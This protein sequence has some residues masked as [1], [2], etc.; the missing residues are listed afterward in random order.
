MAYKTIIAEVK[1]QSPYGYR[2]SKTWAELFAIAEPVADVLSIHT[3]ARWGGS[4]QLISAARNL[5]SKPILAKGLHE[6]DEDIKAALDAGAT[7]VLVVG[8]MPRFYR[9]HCL[10]EPTNLR[11]LS[12]L[13]SDVRAVWN[14]R[15]LT[16]GK[17]KQATFNQAR[18]LFSGWLCQA[19]NVS[20]ID[21]IH[22]GANAVL[23][24][25]HLEKVADSLS[26]RHLWL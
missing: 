22:P 5:T 2:A 17:P 16:T 7:Y 6:R 8:R 9:T 4:L 21:D 20:S 14:A 12:E 3:D 18:R 24:G 19:S 11:H 1:T 10:I 25:T 15:D 23:I 26:L 13:P